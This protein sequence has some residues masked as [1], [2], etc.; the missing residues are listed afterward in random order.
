LIQKK[1]KELCFYVFDQM[2][3]SEQLEQKLTNYKEKFQQVEVALKQAPDNE[4]L[5][6]VKEDLLDVIHLTEDL[7][8]LRKKDSLDNVSNVA[9]HEEKS[10]KANATTEMPNPNPK[11]HKLPPAEPQPPPPPPP[12]EIDEKFVIP[13]HL[14]ILP[15]DSEETRNGKRK[16]LKAMKS[17]IR[18]KKLEGDRNDRKTAWQEFTTKSSKKI[19]AG[20]MSGRAKESIFKSPDTVDG[21]VGVTGSGNS[22]T[23][24]PVFKGTE[25]MRKKHL[26]GILPGDL[27]DKGDGSRA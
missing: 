24:I 26:P 3:T 23:P 14:K 11:K 15:T 2:E 19:K 17:A 7:L 8:K 22:L 6:K 1:K 25:V 13:K 5:L 27:I 10:S 20:F 4:G 12:S 16:R 18:Q 21:K 9:E